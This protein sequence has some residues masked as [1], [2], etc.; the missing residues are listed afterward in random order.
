MENSAV[1][2]MIL[3]SAILIGLAAIWRELRMINGP[4]RARHWSEY[5]ILP[6]SSG[7]KVPRT[8]SVQ[9]TA[10][11]DHTFKPQ[12]LF[13]SNAGTASGA[14]DWVVNDIKLAGKSIFE[15]SGDIPGDMFATGPEVLDRFLTF[16]TIEPGQSVQIVVT[17]IGLTEG[18]APFFA[19]MEGIHAQKR[20]SRN[21][22]RDKAIVEVAAA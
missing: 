2:L 20:L 5:V 8:E 22:R 17:Y 15:Q 4:A 11:V 19:A 14:A 13:I 7:K 16:R 21:K 1:L 10:R 18:G 9:I 6:M 12:R 3:T